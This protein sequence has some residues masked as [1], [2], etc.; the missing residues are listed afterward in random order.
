[1]NYYI[2]SKKRSL[3][4][5][6]AVDYPSKLRNIQHLL[7]KK[8]LFEAQTHLPYLI[9]VNKLNQN[10]AIISSKRKAQKT[11]ITQPRR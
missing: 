5:L 7:E 9:P 4:I 3:F 11:G 8:T 10:P 1:M 6:H 2:F